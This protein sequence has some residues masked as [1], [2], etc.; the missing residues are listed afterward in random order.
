MFEEDLLPTD[1]SI[2]NVEHISRLQAWFYPSD[3]SSL[4]THK[5]NSSALMSLGEAI[6]HY[7][8]GIEWVSYGV[9]VEEELLENA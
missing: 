6:E 1:L 7:N 4:T 5:K 2:L 8:A 3:F 9:Y